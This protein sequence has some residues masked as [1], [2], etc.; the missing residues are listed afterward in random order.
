[1]TEINKLLMGIS[2]PKEN[3]DTQIQ[4]WI[5]VGFDVDTILKERLKGFI[6]NNNLYDAT[7]E[8]I[9]QKL[10]EKQFI[11]QEI[12]NSILE[13]STEKQALNYLASTDWYV[14]RKT[15]RNIAIPEEVATKRLEAVEVLNGINN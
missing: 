3:R 1:M 12:D 7:E 9:K 11:A 15:E 5:D 2:I 14:I 13:I 10:L 4:E 8:E 6:K